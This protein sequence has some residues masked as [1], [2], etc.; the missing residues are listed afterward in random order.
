MNV[1]DY[2]VMIV[3]R[4][5]KTHKNAIVISFLIMKHILNEDKNVIKLN[6]A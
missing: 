6:Y 3:I 5:S 4:H 1:E 2:V